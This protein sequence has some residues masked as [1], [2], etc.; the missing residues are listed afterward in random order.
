MWRTAY[1]CPLVAAGDFD[2]GGNCGRI[3]FLK[4]GISFMGKKPVF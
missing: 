2:G 3:L 1:E 4:I